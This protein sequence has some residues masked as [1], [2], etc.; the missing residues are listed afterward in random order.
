[1]P[2]PS[3]SSSEE[4]LPQVV[5]DNERRKIK[6]IFLKNIKK[7]P[8]LQKYGECENEVKMIENQIFGEWHNDIVKYFEMSDE[9][10]KLFIKLISCP[11]ISNKI[12]KKKF[13]FKFIQLLVSNLQKVDELENMIIAKNKQ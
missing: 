11:N 13:E 7:N 9:F 12:M 6:E 2:A 4:A 10:E 5:S 8:E 3:D 1:M